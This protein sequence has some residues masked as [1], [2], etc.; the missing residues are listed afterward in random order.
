MVG[1]PGRPIAAR[2]SA[3]TRDE[4]WQAVKEPRG[5]R[6]RRVAGNAQSDGDRLDHYGTGRSTNMRLLLTRSARDKADGLSCRNRVIAEMK[7]LASG[8]AR[9]SV[10]SARTV[11]AMRRPFTQYTSEST[12]QSSSREKATRRR[13]CAPMRNVVSWPPR[14]TLPSYAHD[15]GRGRNAARVVERPS[16][17][18]APVTSSVSSPHGR[19][20]RAE[21]VPSASNSV[22][23]PSNR[24][25]PAVLR[26]CSAATA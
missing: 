22:S 25:C 18:H 10:E 1:W 9:R 17:Y 21:T 24:S 6:C 3:P 23:R 7:G 5:G 26:T 11:V 4:H 14:K 15:V 16:W 12:S 19:A 13:V 2:G 20:A 8:C